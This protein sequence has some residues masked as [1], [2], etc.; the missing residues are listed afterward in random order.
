MERR[1]ASNKNAAIA[2]I[3]HDIEII[4][5]HLLRVGVI[6]TV[7]IVLVG[8]AIY[9]PSVAL[10]QP[11][12]GKFIGEPIGLRTVP[13]IIAGAFAGDGRSIIQAGL[14]M[15]ILTPI[16]RVVFSV[17]AFLYERDYLYVALTCVVL[18]L[19][20]FSLSGA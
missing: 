5:G 11:Q 12:Y 4:L 9:L 8:A 20:L 1:D 19:L 15:L 17:F 3:D 6:A 13:D 7:T 14:L 16:L 10:N 2:R 18:G